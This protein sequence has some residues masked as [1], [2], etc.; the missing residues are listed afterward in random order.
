MAESEWFDQFRK[1]NAKVQETI[2]RKAA[3][4]S[5]KK[6]EEVILDFVKKHRNNIP[7]IVGVYDDVL[8]AR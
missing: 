8:N 3:K 2:L 7:E 6:Y 5:C 1:Y 4:N